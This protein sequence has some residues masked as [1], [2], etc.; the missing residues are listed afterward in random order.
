MALRIDQFATQCKLSRRRQS[1]AHIVD[2]LARHRLPKEIALHLGP[3]LARQSAIV[4]IRR[5]PLSFAIPAAEFEEQA[6]AKAWV[7]TFGQALFTALAYPSG[8]GPIEI[9]RA[10][11]LAEFL[12]SVVC[13]LLEGDTSR[14]WAYAEFA[15]ILG[16]SNPEA[17]L[18][19]LC[20][21]PGETLR[22]LIATEKSGQLEKLL[23]RLDEIALDRLM[24]VLSEAEGAAHQSGANQE[25]SAIPML[26]AA[27]DYVS[28]D[29]PRS[30]REL[31][32]RGYA[33]RLY[34]R[35]RARGVLSPSLRRLFHSVGAF[36]CL[37]EHPYI[38]SFP[39]FH[40]QIGAS[41]PGVSVLLKRI[42]LEVETAE[43]SALVPRLVRALDELRDALRVEIATP[44]PSIRRMAS[45]WCGIFFLCEVLQRLGWVPLWQRLAPF[46]SGGIS[47][48]L[49]GL[50]LAATFRFDKDL[51]SLD[52]G[53]ALFAGYINEPDL[54][55]CRSFFR[56]TASSV[57][58]E[59][60]LSALSQEPTEAEIADWPATL[61]V[62]SGRL[63]TEFASRIRG[64]RKASPRSIVSNFLRHTGFI[65]L[66]E[67]K[68][69]VFSEPSPF[70][71]ALHVSGLDQPLESVSWLGH[72]RL[73]FDLGEL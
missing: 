69:R 40:L 38:L 35:T 64:F 62:L 16:R 25:G 66:G 22:V 13:D 47:C 51:I 71:V 55:H 6:L 42:Q 34:V 70:H 27:A 11:S 28:Q 37:L 48:L 17:L 21:W 60:L 53:V 73:E 68:V 43:P 61:Q 19:L 44:V 2:H 12:A 24:A 46:E 63:L 56:T 18:A 41:P 9:Y 36:G 49:A 58:R 14:H 45:D 57:R 4:R 1:A 54:A 23:G 67:D 26:L 52:P 72:R 7:Q 20:Q 10:D 65:S 50:A 3:S 39:E 32:S 29:L 15:E 33:L 5:L 59:I 8:C 30:L 31:K